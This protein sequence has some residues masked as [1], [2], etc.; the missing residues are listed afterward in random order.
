[1]TPSDDAFDI[2]V[3]LGDPPPAGWRDPVAVQARQHLLAVQAL[4]T[5]DRATDLAICHTQGQPMAPAREALVDAVIDLD[6]AWRTYTRS[7]LRGDARRIVHSTVSDYAGERVADY[8]DESLERLW[9]YQRR[10]TMH[11]SSR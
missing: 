9:A 1:M 8:V 5:T 10:Q 7:T 3:M 2:A 4:I 11:E 6:L